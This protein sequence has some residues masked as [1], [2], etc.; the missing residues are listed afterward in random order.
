MTN[1]FRW[2]IL[3]LCLLGFSG[4]GCGPPAA[5]QI[6]TII[7]VAQASTAT[8]DEQASSR[9]A[10]ALFSRLIV[11]HFRH[12]N[13][14]AVTTDEADKLVAAIS[15][16]HLYEGAIREQTKRTDDL[17]TGEDKKRFKRALVR[18]MGVYASLSLLF[19]GGGPEYDFTIVL[20]GEIIESNGTRLRAGRTRC[21]FD[22]AETFPDGY[23]MKARS[24][25]IDREGQQKVLGRVVI[26]DEAKAME[27]MELAGSEGPVLEALRKL[28]QNG[29]GNAFGQ[30]N[31]PT[32]EE[33]LRLRKLRDM[34]L[35]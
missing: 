18:M 14:N 9:A 4:A 13:G 24:I 23:D 16:N 5:F 12:R 1:L 20:P 6:E 19:S 10:N 29:D 2:P 31:V 22:G 27:F 8:S 21:R 7:L 15:K 34:L 26:D 17:F 30:M 11:Q 32:F 28:R 35:K 3:A 25:W 33:A